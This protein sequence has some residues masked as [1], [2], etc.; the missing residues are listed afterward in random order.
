[1]QRYKPIR[2]GDNVV[3]TSAKS[4]KSPQPQNLVE[5]VSPRSSDI[6][7]SGSTS[8]AAAKLGRHIIWRPRR[9]LRPYPG[10][11]RKH[12]ERQ[13]RKLMKVLRRHWTVPILIDESDTILC[14]HARLEAARRLGIEQVPTIRISGLS[15]AEKRAI[16]IADNK[17]AEEAAWDVKELKLHLGCLL[18]LDFDVELTG[19]STGEVDLIIDG[20]VPHD[21]EPVDDLPPFDQ[22]PSVCQPGDEWQLGP[23]RLLCGDA[24][25]AD[26]YARL[27]GDEQAQMLVSDPPYNDSMKSVVGGGK[28]KPREFMQASGELSRVAFTDF[29]A[30]FVTHAIH[31]AAD[32]AIHFIFM[33]WRHLPELL[34][35][36]LPQYDEWKNL[37]VWNKDNAGQGSFYR[38]K[39]E[40]IAVFKSGTAAHINNF[41]LGAEGRYRTNVIDCPSVNSFHP[42]RRGDQELHP[43]TK[44]VALIADLI[45]DCSR[46]NGVILDPFGGSGTTLI[47]AE[48]TGRCARLMEID[49]LYVDVVI[50]RWQ[51][52]TNKEALHAA[53]GRSFN[54][55]QALRA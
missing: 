49:P 24:L 33:D 39:H 22:G 27:M 9:E 20:L 8:G 23:H 14:G 36:A 40:L 10:N 55:L 34:A 18:D 54:E 19:F 50:R 6:A 11:P 38:S 30:K 46:R 45:R 26:N 37:L 15:E 3:I 4:L 5:D 29:L 42:A 7:P 48:R 28:V 52:L 12:P 31:H 13:I 1:M 53:T 47:A 51:R 44:P 41:G 35:A 43:T 2:S 25:V 17:L 16:V 21:Q 32:G